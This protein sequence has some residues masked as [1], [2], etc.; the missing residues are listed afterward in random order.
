[1]NKVKITKPTKE[2]L[3]AAKK[4]RLEEKKRSKYGVAGNMLYITKEAFKNT[5]GLFFAML[6]STVMITLNSL[7]VAF[8]DKLV[9]E[10]AL[11][12]EERLRSGLIAAAVIGLGQLALFLVKVCDMYSY[13]IGKYEF[14]SRFS[15]RLMRKK[16]YL[17]YEKTEDPKINDM[18]QKSCAAVGV[19]PSAF[20]NIR[21]TA[22]SALKIASFGGILSMLNPLLI[23]VIAAPAVA[24]YYINKHKMQWVWNMADNWQ[25]Y[26]RQLSYVTSI[27]T[28]SDFSSAKDIRIFGMQLWLEKIFKKI[29]EKR[30]G[31]YEQQDE[32][33]YR[34]NIL[35]Q[36]VAFAGNL[37][38]DL[39]VIWLVIG[40]HIGAGEFV[41]YF[42]SIFMLSEAVKSWCD[43]FSAYQW[44]SNNISYTREYLDLKDQ[45]SAPKGKKIPEGECEIEF[46]NVSYTYSGAEGP[47]IKN[48]SFKLNKGERL[49][50]VGLNGAGKTTLI[51][52]MCGLY[53]PTEGEIFLNGIK[54]SEYNPL[55]YLKLFG[56]VFQ[57]I[58]ALPVTVAENVS[59]RRAEETDFER[60][61]DCMKKAGIYEKIMSLPQKENTRLC[62]TVYDNATELSGGQA[63][64]LALAKALYKDAPIL[65]LDEPTAAL[66]PIAEQEMY[67]SY[68]RFAENK[69]SVFISH[70]LASTRFCDR[71]LLIAEG[72][73]AEEGTHGELMR[74]NGNYAKL[75]NIQSS[76]YEDGGAKEA[77]KN[78]L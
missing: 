11:N 65:L 42:N 50:L 45:S 55:E 21:D 46:K 5:R 47:T 48:V 78:D 6:A 32:W 72:Q 33:S 30:L 68:S 44:F 61:Y 40:G 57:D 1:M 34:H 17:P 52:L 27:G 58:G 8:T 7:C 76:Y 70:R 41:L 66:D 26:D 19:I 75:F 25:A 2:R 39:Y 15:E 51:K 31:W 56:T 22:V 3:E 43:K 20:D 62:K 10:F 59:G 73:I 24:R 9:I 37:A 4:W 54:I 63:Q 67:L 28:D 38:A 74:L 35:G 53:E 60:V 13:T 69:S 16:M 36:S 18:L 29:F 23:L 14:G 12:G 49:A 64:K 71:I 77:E